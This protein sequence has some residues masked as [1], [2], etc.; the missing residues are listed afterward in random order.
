MKN[1]LLLVLLAACSLKHNPLDN[2]TL[3]GHS[4]LYSEPDHINQI[5]KDQKRLVI[6]AT[7]DIEGGFT[8]NTIKFKDD[9]NKDQSIKIGGD[10]IISHYFKILREEYK[11][12]IL[13]DAGN[14]LSE[15]TSQSEIQQFYSR[16][17]Y[18]AVT[19]GLNDFK[20]KLPNSKSPADYFQSFAQNSST[21]LLLSN[22]YELKSA[23]VVEWKGSL[24]YL[25]KEIDGI[26]VGIIGLIPD[27]IA[28]LTPTHNRVGLYVESMLQSTL[29]HARLLRSLG[30]EIIVVM[31]NQGLDCG[32][33]I[34]DKKN[35]PIEKVNFDPNDK[36]ACDLNGELGQYLVRLPPYLVDVVFA[37]RNGKKTA[38]YINSTL[39]LSGFSSGKSFSYVE[40][41]LDRKTNK[42]IKDETVVHQPVLFCHEF[43]KETKD[44]FSGDS[45]VNHKLRVPAKFL[46][47]DI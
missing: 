16:L 27:D 41:I 32:D 3:N 30:A 26:K 36:N 21:P 5:K 8:P 7:S 35:L 44:C 29:R 6:A 46:G 39:V 25:M 11:N 22:L 12:V 1:I 2:E 28:T 18:D 24:P 4:E 42:L 20:L 14:I 10:E 13:L 37:G 23:R 19:L 33:V 15:N 9:F 40:F 45:S 47:K 34:A 17:K 43:F 38:N 31:T